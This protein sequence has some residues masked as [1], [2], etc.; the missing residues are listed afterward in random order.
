MPVNIDIGDGLRI[1]SDSHQFI[2]QRHKPDS[3]GLRHEWT[4]LY[5]HAELDTLLH[6]V[7]L[8]RT[9]QGNAANLKELMDAYR[10]ER[11]ALSEA[12]SLSGVKP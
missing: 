1:V 11:T 6:C 8:L 5:Y 7:A 2:I 3:K 9:R 4:A 12:V 10:K